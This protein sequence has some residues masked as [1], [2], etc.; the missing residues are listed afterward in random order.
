MTDPIQ[1]YS[2]PMQQG[3][4]LV[5]PAAEVVSTMGYGPG[6]SATLLGIKDMESSERAF[7]RPVAVVVASGEGL[8]VEPVVDFT[9]IG[10]A[11][12]TV[13]LF[14]LGFFIR[15]LN[16]G[17]MLKTLSQGKWD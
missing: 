15:L 13:A 11:A 16:P 10:L 4:Y 6:G 1:V 14:L 9:K 8:R 12:I 3:K 2:Q 17:E 7:S 5:I